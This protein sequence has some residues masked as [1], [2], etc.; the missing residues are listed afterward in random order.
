MVL[1]GLATACGG[2]GEEAPIQRQPAAVFVFRSG[3]EL[4]RW[5][6][7]LSADDGADVLRLAAE[8]G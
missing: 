4:G 1:A 6:R 5:T 7:E 3:A 8:Q 2:S